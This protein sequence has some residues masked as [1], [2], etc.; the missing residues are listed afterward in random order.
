MTLRMEIKALLFEIESRFQD[1]VH[2][3][4][5]L[6]AISGIDASGKGYI[7]NMLTASLNNSG[8]KVA[9]VG[10]DPW[11]NLPKI[12]LS[13]VN[14]GE[15]FYHNAIRFDALFQQLL[16]P[17]KKQR[18][19]TATMDYMQQTENEFHPYTYHYQDI[20][21]ILVEGIF[22]L[23]SRWLAYYDLSIW[24][25]CSESTALKRAI[26]RNQ[27]GLSEADLV[28]EYETIYF[29][30]QRFHDLQDSPRSLAEIHFDNQR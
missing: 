7:S 24:V 15:H 13:K 25:D 2:S 23:Q 30:A 18:S 27:E 9:N 11:Q 5:L 21:I 19:V 8:Y 26:K 29:P 12:R 14:A 6:V 3:G 20:D 4:A 16:L 17:L 10:I 28:T 22:L 1:K